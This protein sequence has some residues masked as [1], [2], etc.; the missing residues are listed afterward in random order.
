L[1]TQ[2]KVISIVVMPLC[3]IYCRH[4]DLL[5]FLFLCCCCCLHSFVA[6]IQNNTHTFRPPN[7]CWSR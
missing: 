6:H 3:T 7:A 2:Q 1:D 5:L 4:I